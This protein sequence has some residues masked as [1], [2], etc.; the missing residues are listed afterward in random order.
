MRS[1]GTPAP[2]STI[3]AR[4][5]R[6]S[7]TRRGSR[8]ACSGAR[9]RSQRDMGIPCES[10][11]PRSAPARRRRHRRRRRACNGSN[12]AIHLT[13]NSPAYDASTRRQQR[14]P[15][16]LWF[17][18]PSLSSVPRA[19]RAL[20]SPT[21]NPRTP[22]RATDSVRSITRCAT[23]PCAASAPRA[24]GAAR[25]RRRAARIVHRTV[26]RSDAWLIYQRWTRSRHSRA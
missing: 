25:T 15:F 26:A 3:S 24:G 11:K 18:A 4:P 21:N 22:R 8:G 17:A 23:A 6:R 10:R 16:C 20:P 5:W 7:R 2:R 14:N 13:G 12:I 9:I 1:T 19:T